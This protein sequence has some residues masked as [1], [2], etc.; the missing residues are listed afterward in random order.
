MP[1]LK[2]NHFLSVVQLM[3]ILR[4]IS[5]R[6]R[7]LPVGDRGSL[8]WRHFHWKQI[9]VNHV[10]LEKES[11]C[12]FKTLGFWNNRFITSKLYSYEE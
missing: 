4:Q 3:D 12:V 6:T 2:A 5:N 9:L 10:T 11:D 8:A 7:I 1:Q